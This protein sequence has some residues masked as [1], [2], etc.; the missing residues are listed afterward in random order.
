MRIQQD[1]GLEQPPS[2]SVLIPLRWTLFDYGIANEGGDTVS[3]VALVQPGLL[4]LLGYENGHYVRQAEFTSASTDCLYIFKGASSAQPLWLLRADR[5]VFLGIDNG[6]GL[7][8]IPLRKKL[9][10]EMT[11]AGFRVHTD[12][13]G[14]AYEPTGVSERKLVLMKIYGT[15]VESVDQNRYYNVCAKK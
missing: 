12:A 4:T 1:L 2:M 10:D 11:D 3:T 7:V 8:N 15:S 9:I 14:K 6:R 5:P 13:Q